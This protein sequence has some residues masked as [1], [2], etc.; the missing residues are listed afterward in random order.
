[1]YATGFDMIG[2]RY[3]LCF[4]IAGIALPVVAA[5]PINL[6]RLFLTPAQRASLDE[7]NTA[8]PAEK[9]AFPAR[10]QP[11]TL[12]LDGE[13]RHAGGARLYWINRHRLTLAELEIHGIVAGR[14]GIELTSRS[15]RI[16]LHPGER[17]IL[18]S[19][20]H[21]PA[22]RELCHPGPGDWSDP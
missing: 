11:C 15:Q 4:W 21:F 20:A 10:P 22:L 3:A 1:M 18:E 13:I 14:S 7:Q 2:A 9:A 16:P 12:R 5:E 17:L 6:G 8:S 19:A